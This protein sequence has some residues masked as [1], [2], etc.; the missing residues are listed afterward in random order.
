MIAA[1][2]AFLGPRLSTLD[3]VLICDE[4]AAA[5]QGSHSVGVACQYSGTLGKVSSCQVGVYLAYASSRGQTLIDGELY[6]PQVWIDDATRRRETGV[7]V[8]TALAT[9]GDLALRL[10]ERAWASGH[11]QGRWV[12]GDAV[13]GSDP[14]L[15]AGVDA[16]GRW[17]VFDVRSTERVFTVQP[18]PAVPAWS[19]RGRKPQKPRRAAA[20]APPQTV[21]AVAGTVPARAW[22]TLTVAEGAQG[23]RRYQFWRKRVWEGRANLPGRE[24]WL[25]L[26]RKLEG[27][28]LKY[29]LSNAPRATSLLRRGQVEAQRRPIETEFEIGKSAVGLVEYEVRSWAGRY[30][31]L[32]M[33]LLAGAFLVQMQRDWGGKDAA[34]Y[35]ATG[36]PGGAGTAAA[37]A[38]DGGRVTGLAA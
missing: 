1:E 30:H 23:P 28:D 29:A 16:T 7:P 10:L 6:L 5:K 15:R 11:W 31:H 17:Y 9:K 2:Q 38:L 26:R 18:V 34:N 20:S 14:G 12:T 37:A 24:C 32:A 35:A 4:T 19:G 33:A 13:Y 22:Q 3:G 25:L 27:S 36:E 21:A 8:T